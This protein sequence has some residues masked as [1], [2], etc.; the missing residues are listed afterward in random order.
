MIHIHNI[1]SVQNQTLN[2]P[3]IKAVNIKRLSVI[4]TIQKVLIFKPNILDLR[5]VFP[6]F[7]LRVT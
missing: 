6:I 7:T 4:F 2:L 1:Y 5:S 3:F